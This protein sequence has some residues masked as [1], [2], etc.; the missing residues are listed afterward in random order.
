MDVFGNKIEENQHFEFDHNKQKEFALGNQYEEDKEDRKVEEDIYRSN[1]VLEEQELARK[2]RQWV[3][4]ASHCLLLPINVKDQLPKVSKF[5]YFTSAIK[6]SIVGISEEQADELM[7]VED[8]LID[9][10][11]GDVILAKPGSLV[12]K[13]WRVKNLG[14]RS[15]P[16]D[17]KIVSVT[18]SL[19]YHAPSITHNLAPGEVMEISIRIYVPNDECDY[20]TVKEYIVRLHSKELNWFGEPL[21]A[22]VQLDTQLYFDTLSKLAEGDIDKIYPRV[23]CEHKYIENYIIAK[24]LQ[25]N[26]NE[27][28][29]KTISKLELQDKYL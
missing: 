14:T 23:T 4:R 28:F 10:S 17:T 19:F 11:N 6:N 7:R 13:T 9:N 3:Y 2:E 21:I 15:W 1:H 29:G 26:S 5:S 22:Y 24:E 27:P 12:K 16:T 8:S 20:D 25:D 18:D